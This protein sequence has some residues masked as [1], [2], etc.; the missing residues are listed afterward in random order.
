MITRTVLIWNV[1]A[2][3]NENYFSAYCHFLYVDAKLNF[4]QKVGVKNVQASFN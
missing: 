2:G 1:G 3:N 4:K